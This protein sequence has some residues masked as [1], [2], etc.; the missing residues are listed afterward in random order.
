MRFAASVYICSMYMHVH[1]ARCL[2]ACGVCIPYNTYVY[3]CMDTR[4][5]A[6]VHVCVWIHISMYL[7]T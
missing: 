7:C 5:N 3:V 4:V 1:V 6:C 2:C